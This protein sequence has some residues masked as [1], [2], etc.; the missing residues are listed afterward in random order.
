MPKKFSTRPT[1][2]IRQSTEAIKGL[3]ALVTAAQ[4]GNK[5]AKD[6]VILAFLPWIEDQARLYAHRAARLDLIE[7]LRQTAICGEGKTTG[8]V[9]RAIE[10]YDSNKGASF[11]TH[12]IYHINAAFKDMLASNVPGLTRDQYKR[13]ER[14]RTVANDLR[15][16]FG[17]EPSI[18]DIRRALCTDLNTRTDSRLQDAITE[19]REEGCSPTI[20]TN[21]HAFTSTVYE[22]NQEA[23]VDAR[24]QLEKI[25]AILK[26][27]S[28]RDQEIFMR[29]AIVGEECTP[30]ARRFGICENTVTNVVERVL[31]S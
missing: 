17:R 5:H 11:H 30:I 4:E 6:K 3:E 15:S 20:A 16:A 26:N 12:A 2:A 7:D 14:L 22:A 10:T 21:A 28:K 24:M 19:V 27:F 1:R 9:M 13:V 29:R 31:G 23:I 8:G 18:K 25:A